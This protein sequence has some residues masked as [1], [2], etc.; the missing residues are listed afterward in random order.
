MLPPW[1]QTNITT[2]ISKSS[3]VHTYDW[4]SLVQ[5]Y[6]WLKI[7][8]V[9]DIWI[10]LKSGNERRLLM[11]TLIL[12]CNWQLFYTTLLLNAWASHS[13]LRLWEYCWMKANK[14]ETDTEKREGAHSHCLQQST[15]T[16]H[17]IK[18]LTQTLTTCFNGYNQKKR[19][20]NNTGW[21]FIFSFISQ[22]IQQTLFTDTYFRDCTMSNLHFRIIS[23]TLIN[24]HIWFLILKKHT[25]Q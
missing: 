1:E 3:A 8:L 4:T 20:S 17:N 19:T 16:P 11:R 15:H 14:T 18:Q 9:E 7:N 13:A 12:K 10:H 21:I 24:S 25:K 5:K 2:Q 22:I 23:F 6:I